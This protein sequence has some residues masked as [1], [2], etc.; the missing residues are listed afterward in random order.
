MDQTT[1][2]IIAAAVPTLAVIA[3]FVRNETALS[4]LAGRIETLNRDLTGRIETS[5]RAL[6]G[7]IETLDRALTG[8]VETLDRDLR[9]WARITM[10]HNT[11]IARLKDKTGLAEQKP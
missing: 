9:D 3:A 10:Q 6:T 11:D 7:R 5:D 1:S 4:G 8:R 2:T